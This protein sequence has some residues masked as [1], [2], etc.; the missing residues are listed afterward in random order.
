MRKGK[1]WTVDEESKLQEWWGNKSIPA[2]AKSLDRSVNAVKIR[3]TRLGLGASLMSGDYITMN[4]LLIAVKGTNAGG[5][6]VMKSWVKNRGLPV[7]IRRVDKCSF[8]VVYLDEFWEWAEKN[9]SF[10][11]FSKMEPLALGEEPPWVAEQ[12]KNDFYSFAIQRKDPW[13][14]DEDDRLKLLLRQH[15]YGY[16]ELSEMLH[17]S[18]GAIQR[19]CN[20]LG[21]KERPVK[22]DNH[23]ISSVWK[24]EDYQRLADGIRAGE[25][26][27]AIGRA[28]GKSEK[29]IRGK[30]YVAYLTE[31]A[32]K[33][34]SMLSDGIWGHG[35]PQPTVKQAIHL[36]HCRREVKEQLSL[37]VAA[38]K[39]HMNELGY[40]P[41]FQRFMC[42]NWDDFEGC[43]AK[44]TDCDSCADFRRIKPQ[45]CARCGCTFYERH[46]NRFC[47]KCRKARIK[48]AQRKWSRH[49]S[50]RI[51]PDDE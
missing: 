2:I 50:R 12:R 17:R 32:D 41:Y 22:A 38:L 7:H 1:H 26:Y 20:D 42:M 48:A 34:R 9:K 21:I 18:A 25:S 14:P 23:G 44:G 11:D 35:A 39:Y 10:I 49:N 28:I 19:R 16:A 40:D 51:Q 33:V 27:T 31:N 15:K 29:A 37:M 43:A 13:T 30:V 47:E 5:N 45:Y 24:D 3:A 36:S 8:R 46:E 4:Q 6:Y